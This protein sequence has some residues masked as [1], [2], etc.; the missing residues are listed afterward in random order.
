MSVQIRITSSMSCST[1]S[2]PM[3]PSASWQSRS[4]SSSLSVSLNPEDGSSSRRRRGRVASDR[5]SSSRRA[6]PVGRVSADRPA[7]G[8]SPT[9]ARRASASAPALDRSCDQ[10]RRISAAARTFSRT[11]REPKISSRW[12]VRAMPSRARL[13]GLSPV[14]SV[15]SKEMR[16]ELMVWRPQMA[17]KHVV[18]PAPLGPMRP[19]TVPA[20]TVRLTPRS[21][22]TPPNRTSACAT[23]RSGIPSPPNAVG[24]DSQGERPRASSFFSWSDQVSCV[25]N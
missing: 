11:E 18:L 13:W 20:S 23:S 2:T 24:P 10:R 12:K 8:V 7:S 19:V 21:A 25:R 14:M 22:C 16:P 3:P 9:R 1:S 15:P 4:P 5:A 17:L 6:C